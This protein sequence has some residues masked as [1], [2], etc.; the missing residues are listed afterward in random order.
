MPG[1]GACALATYNENSFADLGQSTLNAHLGDSEIDSGLNV[2]YIYS[3]T[4]ARGY[5]VFLW[6]WTH[7]RESWKALALALSIQVSSYFASS[8]TL[9]AVLTFLAVK[10]WLSNL[11]LPPVYLREF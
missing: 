11:A 10:F 5:P 3:L 8:F 4:L 9:L 1:A 6:G 7:R 2:N